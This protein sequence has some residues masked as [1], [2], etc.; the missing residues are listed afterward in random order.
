MMQEFLQV[1][2]IIGQMYVNTLWF[3]DFYAHLKF[4]ILYWA[5]THVGKASWLHYAELWP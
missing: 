1:C 5:M 3:T 4:S 2:L